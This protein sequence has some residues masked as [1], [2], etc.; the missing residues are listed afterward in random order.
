MVT[1]PVLWDTQPAGVASMPEVGDMA[2]D[3]TLPSTSGEISLVGL[4]Q[5]RLSWSLPSTSRIKR[6]GEPRWY[7]PLRR[8]TRPSLDWEPMS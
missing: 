3:F 4:G 1:M 8:N 7:P 5:G 2:P 6:R